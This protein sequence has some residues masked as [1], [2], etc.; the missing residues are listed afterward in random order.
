[1]RRPVIL[2]LVAVLVAACGSDLGAPPPT[3]SVPLTSAATSALLP[4]A[5]ASPRA[6]P[7]PTA[8]SGQSPAATSAP[9]ARW[10]V[11]PIPAYTTAGGGSLTVTGRAN[12]ERLHVVVANL[13][14]AIPRRIDG[15]LVNDDAS[16][17]LYSSDGGRTWSAER[18]MAGYGPALASAGDAVYV[19]LSAYA[20][21][22]EPGVMRNA[23]GGAQ[24]AW[25][26]P[27]CLSGRYGSVAAITAA[28]R[29]VFAVTIAGDPG[30]VTVWT[31][32]DRGRSFDGTTL[33]RTHSDAGVGAMA[34][35]AGQLTLV[36]AS[37]GRESRLWTSVDA[38][39]TWSRVSGGLPAGVVTAIAAARGIS[40]VAGAEVDSV[41]PDEGVKLGEPW[42]NIR[43]GDGPWA[44]LGPLPPIP[45]ASEA[46]RVGAIA[47]G[48][49]GSVEVV[50]TP[51]YGGCGHWAHWSRDAGWGP[52]E[53]VPGCPDEADLVV[54]ADGSP[55]VLTYAEDED[56]Y[57]IAVGEPP[58]GR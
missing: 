51:S 50:A 32:A 18:L 46:P 58:K 3:G 4:S 33:W 42:V 57:A 27:V 41:D 21:D 10:S 11:R 47:F 9:L 54:S 26:G 15:E 30:K 53:P 24:G 29:S 34:A 8:A 2:V 23:K 37:S 52:F 6:T 20:C 35:A 55:I 36:A 7:S 43:T 17:Y 12:A 19:A 5:P 25:S 31:S 1:M 14:E 13:E 49:D 38:G 22:E 40:L 39:A 56:G 48:A 16:A 45:D 44:D 28:G